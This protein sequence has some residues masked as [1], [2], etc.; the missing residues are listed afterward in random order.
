M[1][2][3]MYTEQEKR[4]YI[5]PYLEILT[6]NQREMRARCIEL[7]ELHEDYLPFENSI[8]K[9]REFTNLGAEEK[10]NALYELWD[11]GTNKENAERDAHSGHISR[12]MHGRVKNIYQT[13]DYLDNEKYKRIELLLD[14]MQETFGF[15][16][17]DEEDDDESEDTGGEGASG[18]GNDGGP[19]H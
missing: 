1:E 16:V 15:G 3:G 7:A 2:R 12:D 4:L 19:E 9:D 13:Y 17:E 5:I 18:A 10:I 11:A 8:Y 14:I 6:R